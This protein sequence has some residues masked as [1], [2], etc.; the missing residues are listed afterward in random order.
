MSDSNTLRLP[1]QVAPETDAV[2]LQFYHLKAGG[3]LIVHVTTEL[4]DGPSGEVHL[5]PTSV[6]QLAGWLTR[7]RS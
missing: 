7:M 4:D 3:A 5:S 6:D 1:C 2:I